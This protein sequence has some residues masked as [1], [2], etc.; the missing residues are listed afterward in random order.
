MPGAAAAT[1]MPRY[2][3]K[4]CLAKLA[5]CAELPRA[6]VMASSGGRRLSRA[7]RS[8]SGPFTACAC[9]SALS[10][11][12]PHISRRRYPVP[13]AAP[14]SGSGSRIGSARRRVAHIFVNIQEAKIHFGPYVLRLRHRY[15]EEAAVKD[16][17]RPS[18]RYSG[19]DLWSPSD[20]LDAM[21]EGQFAA[22]AAVR[23][24]HPAIERAALA[25]AARLEE[26]GRLAY[27]GAGTSGRLAVQDGAELTPTFSWPRDRLLLLIAGG[28]EALTQAV[29]GAEDETEAAA[30]L[31]RRYG[32]GA[33]DVLIAVAASGTT[34]FTLSCLREGGRRGALTVGIANNPGTPLLAEADHPILLDTGAEAIAGSTR[35][36]AGTAQRI[37]LTLL[38]SLVM[39]LLGRVYRGLMVDLQAVNSK[40]VRRSEDILLHLSGR[41][42]E[43]V[44]KALARA[45]GNVKLALLLL[46]GA[47]LDEARAVLDHAGGRLDAAR[48]LIEARHS[49]QH[50]AEMRGF[51][52]E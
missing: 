38:S 46:E 14:G 52:A 28:V 27:A 29:E 16:T 51:P 2:R 48:T 17:E 20:I 31:V 6:Q 9:R 25:I 3:S 18:P 12:R 47:S 49:R 8:S 42:R 11:A 1:G 22:V 32:L 15:A 36:K 45:D 7:R 21:T 19:I 35:M 30:A 34:P 50:R 37:A 41:D 43:T 13:P 39:I 40:L 4:R 5:A 23:A 24:A 26:G 33:R 10:R 44:R